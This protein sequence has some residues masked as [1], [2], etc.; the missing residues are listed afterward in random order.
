MTDRQL[1]QQALEALEHIQ[2]SIGMGTATIHFGSST[3]EQS[4]AVI[5]ALR[6]RLAQ[7]DPD[8]V[9]ELTCVCGAVWQGDEMVHAPRAAIAKAEGS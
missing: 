5:N 8:P 6:E 2:R 4:D 7:P 9:A 3:W 1:M